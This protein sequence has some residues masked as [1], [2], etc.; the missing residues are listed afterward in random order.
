[1]IVNKV[2]II[3][4]ILIFPFGPAVFPQLRRLQV[5][6]LAAVTAMLRCLELAAEAPLLG[7]GAWGAPALR[8]FW[9]I[10]VGK[11]GK[12]GKIWENTGI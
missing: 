8:W 4:K 11:H 7:A 9:G 3:Y 5:H 1:M 6:W 12:Y 2:I 10:S